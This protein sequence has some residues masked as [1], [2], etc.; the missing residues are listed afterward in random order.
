[1]VILTRV[2]MNNNKKQESKK[3]VSLILCTVAILAVI[4]TGVLFTFGS[5]RYGTVKMTRQDVTPN[6]LSF[7]IKN[8]TL[9]GYTYGEPYNLYILKDDSWEPVEPVIE[10]SGFIMIAYTLAP[11]AK[12][13]LISVGWTWLY[14]ELTTRD[15]KFQKDGLSCEFFIP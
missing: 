3:H 1:M 7:T 12:T 11:G 13:D 14:G 15:Y 5:G 10:N 8:T 9:K 6:G 2:V 4:F